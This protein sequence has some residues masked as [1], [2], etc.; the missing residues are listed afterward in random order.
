ME[1][2][3]KE[4]GTI[5]SLYRSGIQ[6]NI[7][8]VKIP[9]RSIPEAAVNH[10]TA[11]H[12]IDL[13]G[14]ALWAM[15]YLLRTPKPEFN[16][17]PH[18]E[19]HNLEYPPTLEDHD[20]TVPGDTDCRMD[21][22]FYYMR[23]MCGT[24]AG[25]DIEAAF[26]KRILGYIGPD[27]L[28]WVRPGHYMESTP[29]ALVP[30]EKVAS[31]WATAKTLFSLS[32][33]YRRHAEKGTQTLARKLFLALKKLAV[34]DSG[35]A[36]FEGGS[37]GWRDGEWIKKQ[38]PHF[39]TEPVVQYWLAT[40]D[41]EALDFA[42]A[43]AEGLL[44]DETIGPGRPD[45][46]INPDGRFS[47]HMHSTL[48]GVWGVGHLG[49]I[50]GESRYIEWARRVYDYASTHGAGTG[51]VHAAVTFYNC[52]TCGSSD[53]ISLAALM[54]KAGYPEYFDHVERYIRNYIRAAQFFVTPAF[55]SLYRQR[56]GND[57][58][59]AEA[60]LKELRRFEG[61]FLGLIGINDQVAW[62]TED[63]REMRMFGCCAP[64]GMRALHTS[65]ANSVIE[66][67]ERVLVNMSF[68]RE[69]DSAKVIS[70]LPAEGKLTVE[71]SRTVDVFLRPPSW[72]PRNKVMARRAQEAVETVWGGPG[73]AYIQFSQVQPGEQVTIAYPLVDF[74][75]SWQPNPDKPD[76]VVEFDWRGNTVTDV[77]PKAKYL[78]IYPSGAENLPPFPEELLLK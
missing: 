37:G 43:L 38:I 46:W 30:Q 54:G 34:W 19:C 48:H 33:A 5:L 8:G 41:A 12:D 3:P 31:T 40:G 10:L 32:E 76:L 68:N 18:F 73:L 67:P 62:L 25:L 53:L 55:E 60:G 27:G 72:T 1:R 70:G 78:P 29:D 64:E 66:T 21:W 11:S 63:S 61:G 74:S 4:D 15:N 7:S 6:G 51:W 65:W 44:A 39:A 23:E 24:D 26:H 9:S 49:Q 13:A 47:W 59:A 71:T 14:R 28:S 50:L 75:S 2:K 17:E 42:V 69:V 77:S 20:P 36:T 45:L 56:R 16:Y 35:R 58:H 22:E 52:E 57:T